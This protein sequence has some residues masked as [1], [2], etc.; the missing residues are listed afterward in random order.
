MSPPNQTHPPARRPSVVPGLVL[1]A[2]GV[3]TASTLH[4]LVGGVPLIVAALLTGALIG[5]VG[6]ATIEAAPGLSFA[7]KSLLRAGIVLL[8][9]RLSIGEISALGVSTLGIIVA[10]VVTTFFG[11]QWIGRRMGLSDGLSLLVASGFSICGNSAIASVKGVSSA[12]EEEVAA[13]IGLVT[14]FGTIA[15]FALAFGLVPVF[16]TRPK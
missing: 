8:G 16:R 5:N 3:V 11:V 15:V 9:L 7:S 6:L 1:V 13:A 4:A 10:T 2:L 12:D 14:L